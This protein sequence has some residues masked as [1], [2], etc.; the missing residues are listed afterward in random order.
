MQLYFLRHGTAL[1]RA[2]WSAS[3][4]LRPL[5]PAGA[6][7]VDRVADRIAALDLNL[8]VILTSPYERALRTATIVHE[9]LDKRPS[10]VSEPGLEPGRFTAAALAE[11]LEGHASANAVMIVG[12]EPS[13]TQVLGSVIG[14]GEFVL[15]KSGLARVDVHSLHPV[16]GTLRWFAPP[17]LLL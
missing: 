17:R 9:R 4:A 14:G 6:V 7:V 11:M 16:R 13:M 12:H 8:D 2:E 10:L 15:K 3:D 5:S 1:S